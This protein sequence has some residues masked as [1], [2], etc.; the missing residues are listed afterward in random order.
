MSISPEYKDIFRLG[1][2]EEYCIEAK[3]KNAKPIEGL[4]KILK[5]WL[6]GKELRS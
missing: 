3:Y 5:K 6:I 2:P 4:K 1:I